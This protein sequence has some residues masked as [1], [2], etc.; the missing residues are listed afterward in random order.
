MQVRFS[1]LALAVALTIAAAPSA[2]AQSV[3][4]PQF[5]PD[6]RPPA[7][8]NPKLAP[9]TAVLC[10]DAYAVLA[11]AMTHG[12]LWSAERPTAAT[13]S[14]ARDTTRL[15]QFYADE[16]LPEADQAQLE[17]F[18][19]SGFDRGHMEYPAESILRRDAKGFLLSTYT[20][21]PILGVSFRMRAT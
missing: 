17:D 5:F 11:S 9:R 19:R 15:G 13:V 6:G 21:A 12:P 14:V 20:Q 18:R 4:C 8:L 10:N 3:P 1:G 16:R 2:G 7:L